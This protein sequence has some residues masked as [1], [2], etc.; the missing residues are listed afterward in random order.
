[1]TAR[2]PQVNL[3][4]ANQSVEVTKFSQ[5]QPVFQEEESKVNAYEQ[6]LQDKVD[7]IAPKVPKSHAFSFTKVPNSQTPSEKERAF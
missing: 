6:Q 2:S 1:M 3:P 5:A 7:E 4:R